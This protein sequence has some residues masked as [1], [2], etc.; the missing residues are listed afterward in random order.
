MSVVEA[1]LAGH[2][3]ELV[4]VSLLGVD[5]RPAPAAVVGPLDELV[6]ARARG[7][8]AE[9]VLDEVAAISAMRRA[10]LRP[11]PGAPS[12]VP[13]PEDARPTCRPAAVDRLYD[14]LEQWPALVDPWLD[15]VARGGWRLPADIAVELLNRWR[16]DPRRRATVMHL[17]G[18][19]AEWLV[20]LFPVELAPGRSERTERSGRGGRSGRGVKEA[21]PLSVF[22]LSASAS[23]SLINSPMEQVTIVHR[24]A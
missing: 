10:G 4:S 1:S 8:D 9:R 18:A 11:G 14:L 19:L 24:C 13:A 22:S 12:L 17:T 5:R 3:G 7:D 20:E 16:A 6:S 2:W 23:S 21:R 15:G